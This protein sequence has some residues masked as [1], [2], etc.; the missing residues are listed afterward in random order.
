MLLL[1]L[2]FPRRK[3]DTRHLS[4]IL[5]LL[6]SDGGY[7]SHLSVWGTTGWYSAGLGVDQCKSLWLWK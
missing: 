7:Q 2:V 5:P 6:R 1:F 4:Y 3:S